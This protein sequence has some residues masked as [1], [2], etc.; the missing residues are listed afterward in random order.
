MPAEVYRQSVE[1][2]KKRGGPVNGMDVPEYYAMMEELFTPEEA[3][4]NNALPPKPATAGDIAVLVG[5][6]EAKTQAVLEAMADKGLV[7]TFVRQG[8]RFYHGAPFMPG[9]FEYQF[10]PG[11]ATDRD[12]RI[13]HL[14]HAY[15]RAFDAA[16]GFR[17]T[18]FSAT[19][20]IT[21]DRYIP[22]ANTI[23]TYD[24]VA[25]YI[26]KYDPI[27]VGT[28]FCRHAAAL[29]GEDTHNMPMEVCMWFGPMAEFGI[30]RL[31]GRSVTKDEALEILKTSEEAGLIHMSR[32]TTDDVDFICNCD[33]W[34]CEVVTKIL[35]QPRPGLIFNSGFAPEFDEETC[36]ACGTCLE[37]CPA[38]A[39]TLAEGGPPEVDLERCFGCAVCASGC[40]EEAIVMEAKPD[41]PQPPKDI[42]EL[43]TAVKAS[44]G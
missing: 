11:T 41:Y 1:V 29:R 37:R 18:T 26:D 43:I 34:H 10:L 2:M 9:I 6:D 42:K 44:R 17:Q 4:V 12:K 3:E 40:P 31:N 7:T 22:S 20:V 21:V 24:Q 8:T 13:A 14:I 36:V 35:E 39:L 19:R 32:N 30:E 28:C 27:S 5:W 23:H 38:E 33:Q 16:K 15:K 25:T